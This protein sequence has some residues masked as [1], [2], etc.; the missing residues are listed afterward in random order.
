MDSFKVRIVRLG[1]KQKDIAEEI[2]D[3]RQKIYLP[4][5]NRIVNGRAKNRP[6][7][8]Q[9]IVRLDRYLTALEKERGLR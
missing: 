8:T 9:I 7:D 1:L 5:L 4:D 2:S 3:E 6:S